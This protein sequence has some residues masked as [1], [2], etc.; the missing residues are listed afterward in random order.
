VQLYRVEGTYCADIQ[1]GRYVLCSYTG[2]KVRTVQIY[3]VEGTYCADIQG[4]RYVLY[5]YTGWKVRTVQIYRVEGTYCTGIQG[6]RDANTATI[7]RKS[8]DVVGTV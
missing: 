4:G 5:R 1:G 6:G 7:R 3:R 8:L 2:W